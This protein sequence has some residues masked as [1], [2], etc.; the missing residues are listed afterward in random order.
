MTSDYAALCG[1]IRQ[2][3]LLRRRAGWYFTRIALNIVLFAAGWTAFVLVGDSWWQLVTAGYLAVVVTQLTFIGHDAGHRQILASRRGNDAIGLLH[4][5][6][7]AGLSYG[8]WVVKHQR[9]H[10]HPN[11]VGQD[12]DVGTGVFVFDPADAHGLRGLARWRASRQ[13]YLF[14]PMLLLEGLSLHAA[15][16]R[17]LASRRGRGAAAEAAMLVAHLAAYLTV[18]ALVLPPLKAVAFVALH[19]A[20]FGLYLGCTFAPN[21]KGMPLATRDERDFL[22]RQVLTARNIRGGRVADLVFGGLNYQVEHHLFPSM[23]RPN[24]RRSQPLI[25]EFCV[26]R[27]VRYEDSGVLGS[28]RQALRHLHRVGAPLRHPTPEKR[29]VTAMDLVLTTHR[30]GQRL[31]PGAGE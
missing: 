13:A 11:Q 14:F 1:Q 22:R 16:V 21:H 27:G 3:G 8:W 29:L 31:G 24:L 12:P 9:H 20:L 30:G 23:P 5:N 4:G 10:S 6:A 25:R 2:A 28:Y 15:S 26:A 19:Q 18:V 7:L 17:D